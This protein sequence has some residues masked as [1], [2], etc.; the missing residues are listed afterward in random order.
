MLISADETSILNSTLTETCVSHVEKLRSRINDDISEIETD[1]LNKR[2]ALILGRV[3]TI[4]VG[5]ITELELKEKKDRIEDAV[6][7][8]QTALRGGISEGGGMTFLKAFLKIDGIKDVP[9]DTT[10]GYFVVINALRSPF[11]QLADNS[12]VD[13]LKLFD[14]FAKLNNKNIGYNFKSLKWENLKKTGVIDPT[15]VLLQSIINA[16]S[17]ASNLLTTECIVYYE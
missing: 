5:A 3:V 15:Q 7:A 14:E 1:R 16:V 13:A 9:E 4:F 8:L 10:D 6:C 11:K 12:D 2:L 17:I